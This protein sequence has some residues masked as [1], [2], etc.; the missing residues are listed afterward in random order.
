MSDATRRD[1]RIRARDAKRVA[2][3]LLRDGLPPGDDVAATVELT[4]HLM[5][6]LGERRDAHRASKAARTAERVFEASI[7]RTPG[8][9]AVACRKGCAYCCTNFV[10][11]TIPEILA[12]AAR[13]RSDWPDETAPVYRR[14]E[15]A[16]HNPADFATAD[17]S[18]LTAPCPVLGPDNLCAAYESRPLACRGF[19]SLDLDACIRAV[20]DMS[21]QIPNTKQRALFRSRCS[22]ALWAA[23]KACGLSHRSYDLHHAISIAV[24]DRDAERRW[25][26]G[27]DVFAGVQTDV[28]RRPEFETFVD[29]LIE[30]AS[31]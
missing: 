30:R 11:A 17:R 10:A 26:A 12:L 4:R 24:S 21:V 7:R 5:E 14:I 19:A 22:M 1:R 18:T 23:L 8:T 9:L 27:E 16:G 28:S 31:V 13:L 6:I 29:Q 15:A 20:T 25:L 2:E 3:S